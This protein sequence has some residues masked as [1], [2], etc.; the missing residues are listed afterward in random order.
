MFY[1]F[2][3][4]CLKLEGG[5]D[6]LEHLVGTWADCIS[7]VGSFQRRRWGLTCSACGLLEKKGASCGFCIAAA[8]YPI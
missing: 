7:I 2:S 3:D 4:D 6:R 8:S 1:G 5:R